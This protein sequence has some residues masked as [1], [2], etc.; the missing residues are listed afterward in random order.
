M[1]IY[2]GG[3]VG[4]WRGIVARFSEAERRQ[5]RVRLRQVAEGDCKGSKNRP[6]VYKLSPANRSVTS[7]CQH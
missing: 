7:S 5:L 6:P 2:G 1:T 3:K 4:V